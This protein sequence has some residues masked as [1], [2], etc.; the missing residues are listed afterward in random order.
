MGLFTTP[1]KTLDDLF[2]HTLKD[3]YYAE[4]QITKALPQ[5]I[6]RAH[7]PAFREG[8]EQHLHETEAQI[9]R[10]N[11]VFAMLGENASG[12]TCEAIDGIIAEA[13]EV[14]S[15]VTDGPLLDAAMVSS[16]QAVEHY[17]I[18]R[19][20]T[21]IALAKQ[22]GHT[23]V[24]EPLKATLQEEKEADRKLTELSESQVNRQAA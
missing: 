9:E 14:I 16:A 7:N 3:M 6:E 4:H 5:M 1:I 21:L 13:K 12:V 22:L 18:S 2:L 20:G 15:D 11:Q 19:Y 17:E 10:L 8:L 24:V 23:D